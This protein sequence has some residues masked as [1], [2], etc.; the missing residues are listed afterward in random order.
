M[1]NPQ[2]PLHLVSDRTPSG[3]V[4]FRAYFPDPISGKRRKISTGV[5]D[6]GTKTAKAK[7]WAVAL[8]LYHTAKDVSP[9]PAPR[10]KT[11]ADLLGSFWDKDR[12]EY[13]KARLARDPEA[14]SP[15]TIRNHLSAI[16]SHV[17]T[18]KVDETRLL[19]EYPLDEIDPDLLDGLITRVLDKGRSTRT[20]KA[21]I[22]ALAPAFRWALRKGMIKVD[23]VPS[24]MEFKVRAKKRDAFTV[25]EARAL[26][27][28]ASV[29]IVW[30]SPTVDSPFN[31][32]HDP[33]KHYSLSVLT[34]A[35]GARVST[36]LALT[37][38][39]IQER[40]VAGP[41]SV[42]RYYVVKLSKT[43]RQIRGITDGTKTGDGTEVPVAAEI[44]DLILPH[45]PKSGALFASK[46]K[47]GFVRTGSTG[48]MSYRTANLSMVEAM[49]R[50]GIS[51]DQRAAR[52]LGFHAYRHAFETRARAAGLS[53][54]IRSAFTEHRSEQVSDKYAHLPPEDLVGVLPVQLA[55]IT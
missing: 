5:P 38:E 50:V 34:A 16:R 24:M 42:L 21:V 2:S 36:V 40:R 51:D 3:S 46:S 48:V 7:A 18:Y 52:K 11:L 8:E 19:V 12:S 9:P 25:A 37:R 32:A 15:E 31:A 39:D 14:I 1:A 6:D 20:A 45:L 13:L 28:P 41:E 30:A 27:S 23:P 44:M 29:S 55:L 10:K 26:L 17:M 54:E 22:Q 35:T 49:R 47:Y 33:W 53:R 43:Y 4:F